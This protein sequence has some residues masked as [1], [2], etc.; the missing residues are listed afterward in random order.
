MGM[1]VMMLNDSVVVSKDC[2]SFLFQQHCAREKM[3]LRIRFKP[4]LFQHVGKESSLKGKKQT[5]IVSENQSLKIGLALNTHTH[6]HTHNCL[7]TSFDITDKNLLSSFFPLA[8]IFCKDSHDLCTDERIQW[9][10]P[11]GPRG[12]RPPTFEAKMNPAGLEKKNFEAEFP[13]CPIRVWMSMETILLL[14]IVM[15]Q[16][17]NPEE[18]NRTCSSEDWGKC[19]ERRSFIELLFCVILCTL[20]TWV[21]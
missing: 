1:I 18:S 5:L 4:S 21:M 2:C 10:G 16:K 20:Q 7:I 6:M 19:A 11:R 9:R 14:F 3:H 13:H 12:P 8:I 17:I 15:A